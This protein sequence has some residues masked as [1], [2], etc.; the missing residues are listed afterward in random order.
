VRYSYLD[1]RA[2]IFCTKNT[3]LLVEKGF[4]RKGIGPSSRRSIRSGWPL[5]RITGSL[6]CPANG[7]QDHRQLGLP[8]QRFSGAPAEHAVGDDQIDAT[9]SQYG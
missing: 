2:S 6:A 7:D 5:I 3:S 4:A 8:G 1:R 9:A